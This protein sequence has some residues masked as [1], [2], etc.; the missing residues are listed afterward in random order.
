MLRKFT[1]YATALAV[2]GGALLATSAPAQA[3]SIT[4]CVQG[5][6]YVAVYVKYNWFERYVLGK[7]DAW[8]IRYGQTCA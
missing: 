8:Q 1:T 2:A 7:R 4:D 6:G 5:N 3:Y